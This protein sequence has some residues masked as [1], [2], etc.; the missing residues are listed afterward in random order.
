MKLWQVAALIALG[1]VIGELFPRAL[2]ETFRGAALF[3][4][5]PALIFE[6][7]WALD[8]ALMRAYWR[9]IVL[10]AV[11][12]VALTAALVAVIAYFFG[13]AS[14]PNALLLGA[15]L[16]ATD[17]VAVVA[18]FRRLRVPRALATIVESEALLNDAMAVALYRAVIATA[19]VGFAPGGLAVT[20]ARPALEIAGGAA[21][22]VVVAILA[23]FTLRPRI[24]VGLQTLATFVAAYAAYY[25]AAVLNASGIFAVITCA[26]VLR[27]VDRRLPDVE[28]APEVTQVWDIAALGANA[29]LFVLIGAAV[30]IS[31]LGESWRLVIAALGAV[32]VAR[33]VL[34]YGL[35]AIV[36]N[37]GRPWKA[38]VRLADVRG[39]LSLA[40]ALAL[41]A[42]VSQ[43]GGLIAA[44]FAVVVGTVLASSLTLQRRVR[45]ALA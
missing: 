15:I 4:F 29:I 43:R 21:L 37:L 36:P 17:P 25:V 39:A 22:G 32:L 18:I 8:A 27:E 24:G 35:L 30:Q 33:I 3:V 38:V 34:A 41:P 45:G 7:A 12:G 26:I 5:L 31:A 9:P 44:T 2:T 1:L 16:S 10:L 14:L 40:L 6:A 28:C 20:L 42:A 13:G 19:I 23:S 11:P